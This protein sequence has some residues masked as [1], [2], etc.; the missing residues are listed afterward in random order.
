MKMSWTYERKPGYLND[1]KLD[2]YL[3][4]TNQFIKGQITITLHLKIMLFIFLKSLHTWTD[5]IY[6]IFKNLLRKERE[7]HRFVVLLIYI[8]IGCC[9]YLP[10]QRLE[11]TTLVYWGT[12]LTTWPTRPGLHC[13]FWLANLLNEGSRESFWGGV[14]SGVTIHVLS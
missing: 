4:Q 7:K 12:T 3:Y 8:F 6:F 14:G 11:P 10:W 5:F 2:C 1:F 13:A 9:L